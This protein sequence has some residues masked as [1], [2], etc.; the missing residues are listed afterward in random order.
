MNQYD[1]ESP[2]ACSGDRLLPYVLS[3]QIKASCFYHTKPK[4]TKIHILLLPPPPQKKNK[5]SWVLWKPL[6][7]WLETHSTLKIPIIK[8]SQRVFNDRVEVCNRMTSGWRPVHRFLCFPPALA[9]PWPSSS[10]SSSSRDPEG[11]KFIFCSV[12][13]WWLEAFLCG[14]SQESDIVIW[15]QADN[16]ICPMW[17]LMLT[18]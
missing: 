17:R 2:R 13:L 18:R 15:S 9:C 7:D 12:L 16:G 6:G 14:R 10:L 11:F 8:Y 3:S 5:D 4:H 1:I